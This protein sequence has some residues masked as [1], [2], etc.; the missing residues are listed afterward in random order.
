MR[1]ID[2]RIDQPPRVQAGRDRRYMNDGVRIV[3]L[4]S[5]LSVFSR[6][7]QKDLGAVSGDEVAGGTFTM[8]YKPRPSLLGKLGSFTITQLAIT[9]IESF[10]IFSTCSGWWKHEF[11]HPI[12]LTTE[13]ADATKQ[14][15]PGQTLY[16]RQGSCRCIHPSSKKIQYR[17]PMQK[18]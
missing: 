13:N 7:A 17:N 15:Q 6:R 3:G 10:K 4:C 9:A 5:G 1:E 8:T 12:D 16:S 2:N 11:M 14:K 18:I